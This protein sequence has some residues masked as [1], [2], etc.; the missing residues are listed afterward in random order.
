MT[1]DH[2]QR[3]NRELTELMLFRFNRY[4]IV[5]LLFLGPAVLTP[6]APAPGR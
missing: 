4:A 2:E 1:E 3:V 5:G 6:E